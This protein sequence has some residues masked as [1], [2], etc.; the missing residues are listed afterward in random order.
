MSHVVLGGNEGVPK[1]RAKLIL[2]LA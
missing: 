1:D 2:P